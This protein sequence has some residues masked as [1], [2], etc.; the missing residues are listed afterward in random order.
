MVDF[1]MEDGVELIC[2]VKI[3]ISILVILKIQ[4]KESSKETNAEL[5]LST[6]FRNHIKT[7]KNKENKGDLL[8]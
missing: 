8:C 5:E 2:I 1:V 7:V 3:C 4:I 6:N